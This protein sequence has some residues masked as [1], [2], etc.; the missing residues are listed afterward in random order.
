MSKKNSNVP[1]LKTAIIKDKKISNIYLI[2]KNNLKNIKN[3]NLTIAVSGGPDSLALSALAN[4]LQQE[5][6]NKILFAHVD[7]KIRKN[8]SKE[9]LLLKKIL[10]KQK[11]NLNILDND[12]KIKS[13]IQGKAR[14]IRYNLL[15]NFSKIN[16]IRYILTAHHRDDQVETFL[17]RL[18]RGSGVQGL[19]S[20]RSNVRL[21]ANSNIVRPLL[22]I[23]KKDLIYIAKKMFSKI[24]KDPS[25]QNNKYLRT[26]IRH[27]KNIFEEAG[28][29]YDQIIKS[30]KNI[31]SANDT[32]N[33]Y[34]DKIYKV[35]VKIH[36]NKLKLNFKNISLETQEVQLK[37]ISDSL[38]KFVKSYYPP[39]SKKVVNLIKKL[40]ISDKK[41]FTLGGCIIQKAGNYV[42]ITKER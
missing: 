11:M 4:I 12:Q 17:I 16:K 20:M 7:H 40:Q 5:N 2:F 24:I 1:R 28:I 23:K 3:K 42:I 36:K 38:K 35:N 41:K 13:N 27:L 22:D 32:L 10:K 18:S 33:R 34:I 37:I 8:S 31:S 15:S 39:R 26:R 25:N 30:I 29:S 14:E 6:K 19:S 21:N 9:A